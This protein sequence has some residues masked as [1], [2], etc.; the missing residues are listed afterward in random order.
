M[1]R[2][3]KLFE[4]QGQKLSPFQLT[5]NLKVYGLKIWKDPLFWIPNANS[6]QSSNMAVREIIGR[7]VYKSGKLLLFFSNEILKGIA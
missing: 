4:R 1:K 7:I 3:K 5:L 6:L 2:A